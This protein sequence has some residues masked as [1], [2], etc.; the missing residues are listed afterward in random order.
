MAKRKYGYAPL[1]AATAGQNRRS[2]ATTIARLYN[3]SP[4]ARALNSK[5]DRFA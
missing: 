5:G 4:S 2:S 1:G 3:I